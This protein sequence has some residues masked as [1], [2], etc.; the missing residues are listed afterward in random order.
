MPLMFH[1]IMIVITIIGLTHVNA[2]DFNVYQT[3]VCQVHNL[4]MLF[5]KCFD[6]NLK[7]SI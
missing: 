4:A 6:Q 2:T 1:G 3:A 5:T 7:T